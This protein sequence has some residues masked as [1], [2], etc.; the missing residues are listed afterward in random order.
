[1]LSVIPAELHD[2]PAIVNLLEELDRFYGVT[3]LDSLEQRKA[4]IEGLLFGDIP[5]AYVLLAR[6]S[7]DVVGLAS[8]SFLW[9]AAGI[10]H[11]LFLKELYV[12]QSHWRRGI[13]KALM[14]RVCEMAMKNGCSRVE[15]TTES[16]NTVAL[17]FY[18]AL[19]TPLQPDKLFYRLDG[20]SI[21]RVA[22][23]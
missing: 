17:H 19:G 22:V 23:S 1:V 3:E 11:S 10:T 15:W 13:G 20:E 7:G 2:V 5:A 16:T 9:P 14:Q 21:R 8:Y 12:R 6:D 18:E 4:R